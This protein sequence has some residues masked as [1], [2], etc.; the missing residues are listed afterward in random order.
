[1]LLCVIIEELALFDDINAWSALSAIFTDILEDPA[2]EDAYI[3]IDAL[4]ECICTR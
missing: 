2:L 4:D 1:M 3:V